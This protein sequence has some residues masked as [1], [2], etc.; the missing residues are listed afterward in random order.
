MWRIFAI[1]SA[2]VTLI[3][4]VI[5]FLARGNH[6]PPPTAPDAYAANLQV[7][8][9][10]MSRAENMAGGAVTYID[11]KVLNTGGKTVTDALVET[12]FH[13]SMNEV[14]QKE[15]S[16]L[17]VMKHNGVYDDAVELMA[18]PLAPGQSAQFRLIFEHISTQWDQ[19]LPEIRVMRVATH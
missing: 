1:G 5:F 9:I 6:A 4:A 19:S 11:G 7:S 13:N 15:Q 8:E 17:R 10:K 3:V 14:A 2:I 12:T 18:A 16:T